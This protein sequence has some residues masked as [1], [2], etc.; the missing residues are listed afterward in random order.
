MNIEH[1][2]KCRWKNIKSRSLILNT[3][4]FKL[5]KTIHPFQHTILIFVYLTNILIKLFIIFCFVMRSSL[6]IIYLNLTLWIGYYTFLSNVSYAPP[7]AI[8]CSFIDFTTVGSWEG[9]TWIIY[10]GH[11]VTI[12]VIWTPY[13]N[14]KL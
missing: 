1:A 9:N 7:Q 12:Q 14:L 3:T 6:R 11:R 4:I 13:F 2:N 8:L 5:L 10:I